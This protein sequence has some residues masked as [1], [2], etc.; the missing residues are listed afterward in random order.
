MQFPPAEIIEHLTEHGCRDLTIDLDPSSFSAQP[1]SHGGYGYVYRE[2]LRDGRRVAIKALRVPLDDDDEANQLPKRAARELYTWSKCRHLNVLPLL[3]LALFQGQ[4]RMVSSWAE[5][6]SLPSYLE[7]HPGIDRCNM[8]TQICGGVAYLHQTGVIHGDLKGNNVLVS[9][10]GVPVITDFGNAVLEQGT[11]QFT[12]TVKQG[13]FTPRWTAPEILEDQVKQSRE[14]DVYALGMTILTTQETI[15]GKLPYYY[16]RNVVALIKAVAIKNETPKRPEESI[17]SNSLHGDALWLL[18]MSCWE[19]E[20]DKRPDAD[21][22]VEIMKGVTRDGLMSPQ[23]A[24]EAE[25]GPESAE[26]RPGKRQ[27]R[28]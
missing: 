18:L 9:D 17:P 3:G 22:V 1:V 10:Q 7:K 15:T 25:P 13:G 19:Q 6:G 5:N 8:S 21:K 12:E 26:E 11:M 27:R 16:I 24:T 28:E 20:P 4:I 2:K 23:V 14:A